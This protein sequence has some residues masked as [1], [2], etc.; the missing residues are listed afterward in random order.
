MVPN[1][2]E[3]DPQK[4]SGA[5]FTAAANYI[6]QP[7]SNEAT[8]AG[9]TGPSRVGFHFSF[10]LG[11]LP[12]HPSGAAIGL[13]MQRVADNAAALKKAAGISN[14]G[15]PSTARAE[16][17]V[18]FS[19]PDGKTLTTREWYNFI[20]Y[21]I[22]KMGIPD[23]HQILAAVHT[24][25]DNQHLH[26]LI[27]RVSAKDG[28]RW[29]C[30]HDQMKWQSACDDW[31]AA[32]GENPCP[33]R[34][35]RIEQTRAWVAAQGDRPVKER[36]RSRPAYVRTPSPNY[37]NAPSFAEQKAR[38]KLAKLVPVGCDGYIPE[39]LEAMA[40]TLKKRHAQQFKNICAREKELVAEGKTYR[41]HLAAWR[42]QEIEKINDR[43]FVSR[44]DSFTASIGNYVAGRNRDKAHA[45]HRAVMKKRWIEWQ[46]NEETWLGQRINGAAIRKWA[47]RSGTDIGAFDLLNAATREQYRK[48]IEKEMN[49]TAAKGRKQIRSAEERAFDAQKT[50]DRKAI[51][52]QYKLAAKEVP[53]SVKAARLSADGKRRRKDLQERQAAEWESEFINPITMRWDAWAA[54]RDGRGEGAGGG[55][56]VKP[57]PRNKRDATT[58]DR[59]QHTENQQRL[60]R[61]N[62]LAGR[63]NAQER[64]R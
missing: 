54:G 11:E 16:Y 7:H 59:V 23:G 15:R 39:E 19:L 25:T 21:V 35:K 24:D 30:N 51:W 57:L 14:R 20:L 18:S 62:R 12:L 33:E 61:E 9:A 52:D 34:R 6:L 37:K 49:I 44:G 27:N 43:V 53:I 28:T 41:K 1:V 2:G 8:A 50:A 47:K 38:A 29:N 48:A 4:G 13:E 32:R 55:I 10:G 46:R 58:L 45:R 60:Q 3:F 17:T 63:S 26:M 64:D 5:G 36:D 56:G 40:A 22:D 42:D 31:C